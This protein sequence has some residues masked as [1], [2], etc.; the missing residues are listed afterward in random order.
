MVIDTSV[1]SSNE[2]SPVEDGGG[3]EMEGGEQQ[4]SFHKAFSKQNLP[5]ES[6]KKIFLVG[7]IELI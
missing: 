5:M 3:N 2:V 1:A 4:G 6:G 7:C